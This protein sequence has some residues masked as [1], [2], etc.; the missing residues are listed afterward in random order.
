MGN[1]KRMT[2]EAQQKVYEERARM[3]ASEK[4]M[5][6]DLRSRTIRLAH[7]NPELRPHLLPLLAKTAGDVIPFTGRAP[8]NPHTVTLSGGKYVLSTH[9]GGMMGDLAELPEESAEGAR[10]IHVRPGDPW[11]YLWAY[12]TDHQVLAMWRVSD[13]NEKEYGSASSQT[14]LLVKLDKK[15]ELNRVTGAQFR[16]IETA[17]R[18]QE[19][20]HTRALEQWVE[21]NKTTPQRDVDAL[22]REY[23]D[24]RVRPAM[25]RAV[26][27]VEQG[28]APLGFKASPGGFPVERQMKA[29]VTGK[30]YEKLFDLDSV[31]AY[32]KSKGV[33]QDTIDNQATQWARDDV[34][35]DYAKSV[36]R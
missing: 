2:P 34:W 25:D 21:E 17:M 24:D 14:A 20:A 29:Y 5:L 30:L 12:D 3:Y 4:P 18:A 27:D 19:E 10:V 26:R 33:D 31:D 28:V 13:G 8:R 6:N 1:L 32:V 36:L 7:A 22:V 16:A 23:F 11:K 9:S 15:G 35:L